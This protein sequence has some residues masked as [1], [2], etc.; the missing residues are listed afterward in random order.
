MV[1]LLAGNELAR[2]S[3]PV[4]PQQFTGIPSVKNTSKVHRVAVFVVDAFKGTFS[5]PGNLLNRE[6]N[7]V[8]LDRRSFDKVC[9]A[10]A[11]IFSLKILRTGK[12]KQIHMYD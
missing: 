9:E 3:E 2:L 8:Q 12:R 7:H 11:F 4:R 1:K 5:K 6:F 10:Y